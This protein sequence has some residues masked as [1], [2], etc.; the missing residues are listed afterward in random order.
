MTRAQEGR[1]RVVEAA[2]R[3]FQQDGYQTTTMARVAE[4]AG[5]SK[6]LPYHYFDGKSELARA[7]VAGHLDGI[8]QVLS[9][10]PDGPPMAR[11]RWFLETALS[12]AE[13]NQSSYGLYLS[14][15]LQPSTRPMVMEEV[16]RRRVALGALDGELRTV[17]AA[18]GCDDPDTEA[19]VLR[20]TVDGLTQYL[21]M[22]PEHF[23]VEEA[24]ERVLSLHQDPS[25]RPD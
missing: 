23:A 2:A 9:T 7:V 17:F 15:A 19:V 18:L 24:V 13:R 4:A 22:A 5:V 16:E 6:G 14:L 11:L 8:L 20:A 21:L 10:W 12:H 1:Q 25:R 3:V